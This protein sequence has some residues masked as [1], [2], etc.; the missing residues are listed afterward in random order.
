MGN[1]IV[2]PYKF[3][4]RSYQ[5][6][7]YAELDS[8]TNR[9]FCLWHRR[10]GKDLAL[11]NYT[12]KK[13]FEKV[14]LYYYLLPTYTQ[15]KKI[16][17]DGI[18]NDGFKFLDHIP[19]GTI[20]NKNGQEMKVELKN[21]SIIQLIGTDRYD[22]IR[23]T[24]PQGC[25]FSEYAFQHPMAWEVIKPILKMNGGWAVF[26]TTP[27]GKNHSH[28]LHMM[29]EKNDRWYTQILTV[30]DTNL[31]GTEDIDEERK[32]GMS[33]DM[34]QQEYY[35]SYN[36]GIVGGV[37]SHQLETINKC[38]LPIEK[39]VP[40]DLYLDL[41]MAD[42][43]AIIF[44]QNVG[45]EIRVVDYMEDNGQDVGYYAEQLIGRKYNYGIMYLPHD[46]FNKRL[47]SSKTIADQ[48]IALGFKVKRVQKST[49]ANGLAQAR[50]VFPYVWFDED[51]AALLIKSLENY[52]YEYNQLKKCFSKVPR[53][54]WSSHGADSFRYMAIAQA[55]VQTDEKAVEAA[56]EAYAAFEPK[57]FEKEYGS[58][59][60]SSLSFINS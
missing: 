7:L 45:K 24:N 1:K 21:G 22:S 2:V 28:E 5:I 3:T 46:A 30:N 57:S 37:Y 32:E 50:K 53:H 16:I 26:N 17:W 27:N 58:E 13:A 52:R 29:A 40:V 20:E 47:E 55:G 19:P 14:G 59:I 9:A 4:P 60:E 51:R 25:V 42:A 39:G 56:A 31:V 12:I 48:F 54:D 33:E 36:V 11:W 6:D 18:T 41:G 34:I 8:G 43:T 35:C 49:I 15:A 44:A 23:G 38:K 10:A